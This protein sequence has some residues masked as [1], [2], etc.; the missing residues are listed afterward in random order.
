METLIKA[1]DFGITPE[2]SSDCSYN[3]RKALEQ[4]HG[5]KKTVLQFA[6]GT[7]HF[8]PDKAIER[9]Y[10]MSNN[11]G[12]LKRIAFHLEKINNLTVDGQGSIFIFHG[13]IIPFLI[14]SCADITI[15]NCTIDWFDIFNCECVVMNAGKGYLDLRIDERMT[16]TIED[17]QMYYSCGD[18]KNRVTHL[19]EMDPTTHAPSYRSGDHCG[20]PWGSRFDAEETGKGIVRIRNAF[21]VIPRR[22]SIV[23]L[24]WNQ[25]LC[26]AVYMWNSSNLHI[27]GLIIHKAP[28]MGIL[29][30][31][32]ADIKI[33]NCKVTPSPGSGLTIS[34]CADATHFVNCKGLIE[35]KN[36]LFENQLDDA[37]NIH[38]IYGRIEEIV[39]P[40]TLLIRFVHEQQRG[41]DTFGNGDLVALIS[42]KQLERYAEIK[43]KT[44]IRLNA[45][46]LVTTFDHKLGTKVKVGDLIENLTWNAD[47]HI[48]HCIARCNRARGFL[49]QGK[50]TMLIEN[51]TLSPGGCGVNIAGD[52]SFWY[53]SGP[54]E[55]VT[56]QD[57]LFENC[58]SGPW[59]RAAID[60]TPE[61]DIDEND[62]VYHHSISIKGNLFR[63][64]ENALVYARSTGNL[65]ITENTFE[66]TT[67]YK[68]YLK[69]TSHFQFDSC[70][71]VTI[72][73]PTYTKDEEISLYSCDSSTRST[74]K[75]V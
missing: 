37:T 46:Y 57:N 72:E 2:K 25:R 51:N 4:C 44:A 69:Q 22:N 49:L 19:I 75:V 5:H 66:K 28:G 56:I 14:D 73:K 71:D 45:D 8:Y 61:I 20:A 34:L 3:L 17:R 10:F 31:R 54:V 23:A 26:P 38:G 55:N 48:H 6:K 40:D 67:A 63:G 42:K 16:Y 62:T 41:A 52:A 53:E 7:Y 59:N 21:T 9:H 58:N 13:L 70:E 43:I 15:K 12:S 68:P 47:A 29:G 36:C 74:L 65:T 27:E 64:F 11:D 1:E 32:C 33:D 60:I 24:T 30:V 35:M 18:W 50:G 39:S